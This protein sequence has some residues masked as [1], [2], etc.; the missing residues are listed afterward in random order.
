MPRC[1]P[2]VG[3]PA[4]PFQIGLDVVALRREIKNL[5]L[6]RRT[7]WCVCCVASSGYLARHTPELASSVIDAGAIP[8]LVLSYREPE[9]GL[10]RVAASA[11]ADIAKHSQ[12][13]A[14]A[15]VDGGAVTLLARDAGHSDAQLKRQVR[16]SASCIV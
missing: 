9:L 6:L 1:L 7:P 15:V 11:L 12:D 4:V 13:L 10:K 3:C 5:C 8:L 14:Q 16:R 2:C